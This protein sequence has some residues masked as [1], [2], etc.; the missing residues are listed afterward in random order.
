MKKALQDA[1]NL[2]IIGWSGNERHL[3]ELLGE[4]FNTPKKKVRVCNSTSD[5]CKRTIGVLSEY[6][7]WPSITPM[8]GGFSA[9]LQRDY[10]SLTAFLD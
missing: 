4:C 5:G 8:P 2:L 10:V 6:L 1:E 7:K 9:L 3:N